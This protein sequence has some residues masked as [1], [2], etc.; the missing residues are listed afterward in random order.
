[1]GE[2]VAAMPEGRGGSDRVVPIE[3][4]FWMTRPDRGDVITE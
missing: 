3:S 1:M 4:R 2:A